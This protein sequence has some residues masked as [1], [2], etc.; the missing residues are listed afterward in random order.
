MQVL[1][2]AAWSRIEKPA[3]RLRY[4]RINFFQIRIANLIFAGSVGIIAY[5]VLGPMIFLLWSSF[6]SALPTPAD[7]GYF[8]LDNYAFAYTSPITYHLF[9][10]TVIFVAVSTSI[11]VVVAFSFAWLIERTDIPAKKTLFMLILLPAAVPSM[12][13]AM[14]YIILAGPEAGLINV[15]FNQLFGFKLVNIYSRSWLFILNGLHGV[16][17]T[18][19]ILLGALRSMDPSL[20]EAASVSGVSRRATVRRVTLPMM[21]PAILAASI[22]TGMSAAE[23]FE[24]PTLI[25]VP[26]GF[27]VFSSQVYLSIRVWGNHTLASA[28]S[29]IFLGILLALIYFYQRATRQMYRYTTI[30]GKGYRPKLMRIGGW[31]FPALALIVLF[32]TVTGGLPLLVFIGSSFFPD[33]RTHGLAALAHPSLE[34][35]RSAFGSAVFLDSL[36]NTAFITFVTPILTVALISVISW[37]IV[38]SNLSLKAKTTLDA[39][40]FWP[41]AYPGIVLGVALLWFFIMVDFP[42]VWGTLWPVILGLTIS[43]MPFTVRTLNAAFIQVHKELEEAAYVSGARWLVTFRKI[44]L[45]LVMPAMAS[46]ALWIAIHA[47]RSLTVPMFLSTHGNDVLAVLVWTYWE[48]NMVE[49]VSVIGLFYLVTCAILSLLWRHLSFRNFAA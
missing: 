1:K 12:L 19:L 17:A 40:T 9:L 13:M 37:L 11:A 31:K 46:A 44:L 48:S 24:L 3:T 8:T 36:L 4:S 41:H 23:T 43:Y 18:F 14:A 28:Y 30:S 47:M 38:R 33:W 21:L 6:R 16:P 26:I 49:S 34:S 32:Y 5:L 45:P 20:E 35:F 39:L 22:Y 7:T 29:V 27:H 2:D 42:P 10:N 25:G 15:I